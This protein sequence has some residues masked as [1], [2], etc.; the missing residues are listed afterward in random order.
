MT[1]ASKQ[2]RNKLKEKLRVYCPIMRAGMYINSTLIEQMGEFTQFILYSLGKGFNIN[3][4]N[5]TIELGE[6]LIREEIF[7]LERW[8]LIES[9]GQAFILTE[10]GKSYF[11]V[12]Q[13]VEYVNNSSTEVQIN[14][15]NGIIMKDDGV[16][17]SEE[18]CEDTIQKLKVDIV[19]ELYQNKDYGNSKE[20]FIDMFNYDIYERFNL[21]EEEIDTISISLNYQKSIMYKVLYVDEIDPIDMEYSDEEEGEKA[22]ISIVRQIIK[23]K[24]N[25]ENLNLEKYRYT[26]ETLRNICVF[27]DELLSEKAKDIIDLW[28]EEQ[29]IQSNTKN[30][31]FDTTN[32]QVITDFIENESNFRLYKLSI[33]RLHDVDEIDTLELRMMLEL[34]ENYKIQFRE[35]SVLNFYSNLNSKYLKKEIGN[36]K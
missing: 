27:D 19:K 34:D 14:C 9:N 31:Y 35:E 25:I 3:D 30:I 6:Y 23:L 2:K 10:L 1:D 15:F 5:R 8:G 22:D 21:S 36:G 7:H 26:L 13:F 33:P 18:L 17:I 24:I 29:I 28:K 32:K 12:M 4:I 20:L 11:K 16:V